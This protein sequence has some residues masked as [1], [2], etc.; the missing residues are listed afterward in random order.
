[1]KEL[2]NSIHE[3]LNRVKEKPKYKAI[4]KDIEGQSAEKMAATFWEYE[5]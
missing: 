4:G 2:L 1:M 5:K 3:D